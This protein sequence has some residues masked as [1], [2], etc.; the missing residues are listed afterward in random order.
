MSNADDSQV[1]ENI[2][3]FLEDVGIRFSHYKDANDQIVATAAWVKLIGHSD[4]LG[5]RTYFTAWS[6]KH[7]QDRGN[8]RIGRDIAKARLVALV[9]DYYDNDEFYDNI[10]FGGECDYFSKEDLCFI[11]TDPAEA[12]LLHSLCG[13]H[14]KANGTI[15]PALDHFRE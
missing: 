11:T 6:I 5:Q 12:Q 2:E 3:S 14:A 1:E 8:A 9:T 13:L 7:P 10:T 4:I 15:K